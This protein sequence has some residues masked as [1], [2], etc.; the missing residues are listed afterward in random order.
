LL[1]FLPFNRF[2][3]AVTNNISITLWDHEQLQTA[4]NAAQFTGQPAKIHLKVDTGMHRLGIQVENAFDFVNHIRRTP[5]IILEGVF[6]H[7]SSSDLPL[8]PT[9]GQQIHLFNKLLHDLNNAGLRPEI[10]HASNSAASLTRP[11]AEYNMVRTGIAMYG[12]HPSQECLLPDQFRPVMTWKSVLSQVKILPAGQGVSYGHEYIT[13]AHERIGTIPVGYADGLRRIK[14][15]QVL[16]GGKKVPVI[17]RVCMDQC[18]VQLDTVPDAIAGDEVVLIGSQCSV[19]ISADQL[20]STWQTNN[21]E[22]VCGIAARVPRL[23]Y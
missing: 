18:C 10:I 22:V 21:Y 7:F 2:N 13:K 23:Y 8:D 1:G 9:T 3:E 20:A 19:S 15:N 12:L 16:I 11:D 5:G 4:S 6:T 17:G 14:G